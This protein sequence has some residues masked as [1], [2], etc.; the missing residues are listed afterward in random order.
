MEFNWKNWSTG[1][2]LIF[3]SSVVA[4]L[5]LLLPWADMGLLSV[6]G[7]AQQGYLL[8]IFFIYP[9]YKLLKS[10]PIKPLYGFLSSGLAVISSI[11]F[12]LSKTVEVFDTT[13]NLS[14]SGLVLFIICS[15]V[16]VI[17]VYM[18]KDQGK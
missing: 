7:F 5:S 13:V 14:G 18:S 15:I 3:A 6:N 12:A 11:S 1:Q 10:T 16:L 17:G 2:R 4:V 9:L 8:L